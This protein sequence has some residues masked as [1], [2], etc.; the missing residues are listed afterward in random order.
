VEGFEHGA[1]DYIGK[2]FD[3]AE[4]KARIRALFELRKLTSE[5]AQQ[6]KELKEA[7]EKL[8]QEELKLIESEKLR[9]LGEIAAGM[10]HELHNCLNMILHGTTPIKDGL[11]AMRTRLDGADDLIEL[12]QVVADAAK[13]AVSVTGELKRYAYHGKTTVSAEMVDL[14]NLLRSTVRLFGL[15]GPKLNINFDLTDQPITVECPANRLTQVFTN[16][17][18]NGIEAAG[19]DGEVTIRTRIEDTKAVVHVED[20]G[21]GVEESQR[22]QLFRAFHTTKGPGHGLGL[23]LALSKKVVE[24]LGGELAY[25]P[26]YSDGARFVVKIPSPQQALAH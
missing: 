21:P 3:P 19:P 20:N 10:A 24:E 15:S 7:M 18:K 8:V 26:S 4:L 2:P 13:T 14:H 16:L 5:L 12:T 22:D 25:D 17:I 11:E 1:D 23:G 6:S 9:T